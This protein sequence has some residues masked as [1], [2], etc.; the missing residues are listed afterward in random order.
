M[1]TC[2]CGCGDTVF[3]SETKPGLARGASW[4]G[5]NVGQGRVIYLK[6]V[7]CVRSMAERCSENILKCRCRCSGVVA[8]PGLVAVG[9][10]RCEGGSAV[11]SRAPLFE[12]EKM[13]QFE[14]ELRAKIRNLLQLAS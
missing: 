6:S 7:S 8:L 9:Y 1:W 5:V 11:A 3:A 2:S 4:R 10:Y 12:E 13:Q 14:T